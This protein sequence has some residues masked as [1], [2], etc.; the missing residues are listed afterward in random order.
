MVNTTK[1]RNLIAK[2]LRTPKY[3]MRVAASKKQ[4][5]RNAEKQNTQ[6]ELSY[7]ERLRKYDFRKNI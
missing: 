6:K 3:R 5:D 1:K 2:D 7:V 4:F